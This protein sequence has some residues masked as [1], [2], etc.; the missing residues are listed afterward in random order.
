MCRL[1]QEP[2]E[3][4]EALRPARP[5]MP[6]RALALPPPCTCCSGAGLMSSSGSMM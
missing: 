4:S 2:L 5:H 6:L 3:A 1:H